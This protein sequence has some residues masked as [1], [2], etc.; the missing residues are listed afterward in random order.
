MLRQGGSLLRHLSVLPI[1]SSWIA[2]PITLGF[3]NFSTSS[4][5]GNNLY[6]SVVKIDSTSL[7]PNYFQPW[8]LKGQAESSGSGF[9]ITDK[10][11]L[12]NAHVVADNAFATVRRHGSSERFKCSVHA[13][14][15]ECDLALLAVEEE[16]F[17]RE[18]SP[19]N[20]LI[21][22]EIPELQD[23]VVVVGYPQVRC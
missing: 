20:P 14:A 7:R 23:D 11:I 21:L 22:G 12:T 19:L 13:V 17:W 15:H 8:Q 1:N 6:D 10:F 4:V 2:S 5:L 3:V 18:P 9:A 16:R